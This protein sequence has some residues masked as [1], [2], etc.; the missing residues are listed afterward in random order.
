[1][2]K[3]SDQEKAELRPVRG[4]LSGLVTA[5]LALGV[6]E[7]AA[8]AIGRSVAPAI[9]VGGAA[10]D[11]TP[12]W[13]KE[14]A[15]EQFGEKDKIVLLS[16]IFVTVALLAAVIGVIAT[17]WRRI[18]LTGAACLGLIAALAAATRPQ[19]EPI[20]VVPSLV[21]AVVAVLG[22]AWLLSLTAV[23]H[24]A[25]RR[26]VLG[27]SLLA[28]AAMATG[29]AGRQIQNLRTDVAASR[30][31]LRLPRPAL[32]AASLPEGAELNVPGVS[33]FYTKPADFY[34]VDTALS[35]PKLTT[36]EWKLRIHGMVGEELTLSFDDLLAR[37]IVEH[38]IT[39]TCVSNEVGGGLVGTARWLGVELAPLLR[40]VGVDAKSDQLVGTSVDGMTIGTP[41]SAVLDGRSA[42]LA[43]AMNG[44]PL[45]PEHGF[46]CRMVVAGLYGY[47]SATKWLVDLELSRFDA[48][49]PYWVRRGWDQQ[50][51]IK[52]S[53][54]ID[55]PRPLS[56]VKA[57]RIAVAGVAWA[58]HR[59][60]S[61]VQV[62]V[63][64]GAWQEARLS[65]E[66]NDD[67]WRQWVWEW[68]APSGSHTLQVRAADSSGEIQ[69]EDRAE[70]FPNGSSGWQ[71]VLV[72]VE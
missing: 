68:D 60:I 37:P 29:V 34:R 25:G 14:F 28:L 45:L 56:R 3:Q 46:P 47:V 18:G 38:D 8:G 55:T 51:P 24:S 13:L 52:T 50:A 54:R 64:G 63:D 41:V 27:T 15:I 42:L 11:R 69:T 62:R 26:A 44:E 5:A 31:A 57:G 61:Q 22:L 4:A 43:I 66:V 17:R 39:M 67:L 1:M 21:A 70:P 53:S 2:T 32:P 10:I 58:Q 19:F 33:S 20:D 71:S 36:D 65:A 9:V 16:G 35:V 7:L 59:G 30:R 12:R 72:T 40:E 23:G 48:F 6:A 49:D